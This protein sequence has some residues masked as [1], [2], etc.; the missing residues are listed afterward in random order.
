MFSLAYLLHGAESFWEANRFSASQ[1]IPSIL[2]NLKVYYCINKCPPSVPI[3]SQINPEFKPSHPTS[4][5]SI[6]ILSSHLRLGLPSGLFP[7]NFPTKIL[8]TPLLSL[9]R[10]LYPAHLITLDVITRTIFGEQ[11]KSLSSTLCS[12]LHSLFISSPLGPN[13]LLF[14][15]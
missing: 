10:A 2:W 13:I 14:W 1:E 12:F 8:Y 3:L 7:L 15:N 5:R 9:I 6:L 11:F 4:W